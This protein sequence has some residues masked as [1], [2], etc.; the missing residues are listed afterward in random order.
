MI[1]GPKLIVKLR[2][3]RQSSRRRQGVDAALIEK[4]RELTQVLNAKAQ[5]EMQLK[6]RKGSAE[7]LATLQRELS[8][9]EDEYQQVQ[10]E[11]RKSSPQY[12][13]LT[14]P[15]PLGLKE[16]QQQLDPDTLLLEYSLGAERSYLWAVTPDSLKTYVLPKREEI[17]TVAQQ[18]YKSLVARSVVKSLE[19]A[20]Q[21]SSRS[22]FERRVS[23]F[24]CVSSRSSRSGEAPARSFAGGEGHA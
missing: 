10:A 9:L 24:S 7:E 11:I 3:L 2:H 23:F 1:K 4:E 16:I 6:V 22:K 20:A 5:R 17:E 13:A 14:H 15:Q 18:A 12:S 21:R 8:R 19:T